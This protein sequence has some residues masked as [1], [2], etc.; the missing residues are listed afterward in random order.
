[1]K[2]PVFVAEDGDFIPMT[3][4]H[5]RAAKVFRLLERPG[6]IF[7]LAQRPVE[8][9][10]PVSVKEFRRYTIEVPD[11]VMLGLLADQRGVLFEVIRAY[12]AAGKASWKATKETDG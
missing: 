2:V 7:E 4:E 8:V 3:P 10:A 5:E 12:E 9:E 1:M 11:E 6:T